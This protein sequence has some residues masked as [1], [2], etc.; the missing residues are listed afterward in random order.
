M[1]WYSGEAQRPHRVVHRL[2]LGCFE[3]CVV[4]VVLCACVCVLDMCTYTTQHTLL[5]A[6]RR[7]FF[8]LGLTD[9]ANA[10]A[11]STAHSS[12][13]LAAASRPNTI[14]RPPA[15]AV[16]R[17]LAVFVPKAIGQTA[18]SMSL[19][20]VARP[21]AAEPIQT[22]CA[23][24]NIVSRRA[25]RSCRAALIFAASSDAGNASLRVRQELSVRGTLV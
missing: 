17:L 19:N 6:Q 4:C 1:L 2:K 14:A 22:Y 18:T 21:E 16:W 3:L 8:R 20:R 10:R 23:P 9:L 5:W 11:P 15:K 24:G 25:A 13:A 7:A 12:W